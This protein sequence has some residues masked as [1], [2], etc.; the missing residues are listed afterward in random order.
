VL[1]ERFR[2]AFG[3]SPLLKGVLGRWVIGGWRTKLV[4][5]GHE[6]GVFFGPRI[7]LRPTVRCRHT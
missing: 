1:A 2:C 3:L 6:F 4:G 5:G 7:G